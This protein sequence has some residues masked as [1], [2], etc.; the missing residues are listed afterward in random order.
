MKRLNIT[1]DHGW[2]PRTLR[3]QER[4]IQNALLR[5]RVMAVRLVME[6]YLGK[7]AASMVNVCRHSA[8]MPMFRYLAP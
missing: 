2:M 3:K 1:H 6:G 5:Q 7:E 4:K 8:I